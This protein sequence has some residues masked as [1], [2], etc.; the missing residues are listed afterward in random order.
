MKNL[1]T[2]MRE[3]IVLLDP[4]AESMREAL[5][6]VVSRCVAEDIVPTAIREA[7]L[8][9][10]Y[11]REEQASTAIGHG[12][13]IPH[14]YKEG[15][16]RPIVA[17][18]RLAHRI[19]TGTAEREPI[20]FLFVLIGPTGQVDAHLDTLA[21]IARALADNEVRYD[22]GEARSADEIIEAFER[23][24]ARQAPPAQLK[25][26]HQI[27][28]LAYTGRL[29]GG[30]RADIQRRSPHF[31]SDFTDGIHPKTF[32]A[33]LFLFFACLAPAVTFG[34][35][36]YAA[37]GGLIGVTEM[38]IA[39]AICGIIYALTAGQPLVILG[40]T[41]PLLI[42]TGILYQLCVRFNI[43][44][45]PCY[46]LV[47]VWTAALLVILAVTDASCWIRCFTRF[48]DEIFAALISMIFIVEALKSIIGYIN[49]S[50]S[51]ELAH[52]VAFL[53]LIMALGTFIVAMMLSAFRKSRYLVPAAREFLADFGP[54][55]AVLLM[56]AFGLLFPAVEP[57]PLEV[58][59][60][61]GPTVERSWLVPLTGLPVW[62]W[63]AAAI[64][65]LL[66]TVLIYL[67]Q[68]ITARLVNS[69]DHM[70]RKGEG[71]HL[72]LMV[73]GL[74][75][76]FCSMLGMP[77]LVAAT[78]RS[79]NHVRALATVEER[80]LPSGD[81]RDEIVHVRES[82][83]TPLAV[84][85]LIAGMLFFLP[86]LQLVPKAVLYGL[87][88][89]MGIVSISGNQFFERIGLWLM[90]PNLYP[91]THY[92]RQVPMKVI[93]KF[94]L[95]QLICLAVLWVVKTSAVGI[96]FPMFI[97]LLVPVRM[98][99]GKFF[100]KKHLNALDAEEIP[101]EESVDWAG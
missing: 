101:A 92:I 85:L 60:H 23:H 62:V 93:H 61:F 20:R 42:F 57:A 46:A 86:M 38:L 29:G 77:W 73:V 72:D 89:Y 31:A 45:L 37:T 100:D 71:Y 87:F 6:Q 97:A 21:A 53:S 99:A 79:L 50:R 25:A 8:Q 36:M 96:L 41:G 78:V 47:G 9:T 52:D 75:I 74:L 26:A 65:A 55:L 15:V 90:D 1:A 95:L 24:H 44:F 81:R 11:A 3:G 66:A 64:P 10:L 51:A 2:A 19:D 68:N 82:R 91:R 94:T 80:I 16:V 98:I 30:L 14:A 12:V 34:G 76:G 13:A 83:V 67:D 69:R 27:D 33:T 4:P 39:T 56:L 35:L 28:G 5:A 40:G 58:P 32:T 84:H 63:C 59:E 70:L 88:L 54:T 49:E 17:L 48:T 18:V 43:P 22:L 7:L